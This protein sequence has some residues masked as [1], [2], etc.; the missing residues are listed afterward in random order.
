VDN[1]QHWLI[2]RGGVVKAKDV[3]MDPSSNVMYVP[4]SGTGF[5]PSILFSA[6]SPHDGHALNQSKGVTMVWVAGDLRVVL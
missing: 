4:K 2:E 6:A 3:V 5:K 1:L